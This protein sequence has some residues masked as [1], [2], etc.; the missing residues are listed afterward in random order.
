MQSLTL[1]GLIVVVAAAGLIG[2]AVVLIRKA[3]DQGRR[4]E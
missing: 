4:E 1:V 2:G 3:V